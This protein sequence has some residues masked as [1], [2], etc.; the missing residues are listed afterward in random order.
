[1]LIQHR[2]S[3]N[4]CFSRFRHLIFMCF[5]LLF[6][7][8]ATHGQVTIQPFADPTCLGNSVTLATVVTSTDYGTDSYSFQVIPYAPMDTTIG[9]PID[10]TLTHCAST[11]GGKD[12]CW[13][14]PYDIGFNFCFFSQLYTQF[15]VGSNGWIGFRSPGTNP[16]NTFT[17][18]II[19]NNAADSAAPKDCIFAPWQD[20]LP[21]LSNI[22]NIFYYTIGTAPD[23]QLVVYWKN[24]PMYGC[25]TT[26]GSFQIVLKE[27]GGIIENHLQS[28]PY[29]AT[30]GNKA[31]QGVH[32]SKGTAA[33]TAVV[34]GI[35]RNQT[36]WTAVQE[37]MR[38]VPDGV[39]WHSGSATGPPLGYG[40]TLTFSPTVSTWVYSV[41][42]TCL[43]VVHYDSALVHVVPTLTGPLS[44]CKGSSGV[45]YVTEAGMTNYIWSVSAGGSVTGGGDGVSNTVTV[46]WNNAGSQTVG[47]RFTDPVT[48]CTSTVN[49][50]LSIT[51][52]D[53]PVPVMTGPQNLCLNSTG[54]LYST[55]SGKNN[56]VWTVTGGTISSGGGPANPTCTVTWTTAGAQSISV[57]YTDPV[58]LCTAL[59]PAMLPVTVNPLPTPS[60]ISGETLACKGVPGKLYETQP[61]KVNYIWNITGGTITSGG[62]S[63][64]P[65]ATV[66]WGTIGNQTISVNY[67]EPVTLCTAAAP[68][69]LPVQVVPLPVPSIAGPSTICLDAPQGIYTTQNAMNSYTWTITPITA[70]T[71]LSGAG[72]NNILVQW[73]IPGTHIVRVGYT[74]ANG[75]T[76]AAPAQHQVIVTPIPI[77]TITAAPG[78]A[79]ATQSHQYQTP[80]DPA[81]TFTWSIIPPG[82]GNIISGQGTNLISITWLTTGAATVHVTGSNNSYTCISASFIPVPV[83]PTP[84]PSFKACF[85]TKTTLNARKITLR[86]ASPFITGQGIFSG[87]GVSS[88]SPGIFEFNPLTAGPGTSL[89]SYTYTNNYG[90]SATTAAVSIMVQNVNF[91]CGNNLIDIRDGKIYS[92]AMLSGKCWMTRNLDYG[93]IIPGPY[94][95]AQ[96]DNCL[97]EKYCSPADANCTT[98]G[99]FYQWDEIMQYTT[100]PGSKGVC[101]PEWH[102][103]TETEWQTLIDNIVPGITAPDAN[104]LAGAKLKDLSATMGFHGLLGGLDYLDNFWAFTSLPLTGTMFWTST[105]YGPDQAVARG[106]NLNNPS[107]SHYN[108]SRG[109][110]YP[111]RCVKD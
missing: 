63:T 102:L 91:T 38:F 110:A 83:L 55:Q 22:N 36:N 72:T 89:I 21:T 31:T 81:C 39:S 57:L 46:T 60:F 12:D 20:W 51:V 85:D 99:G 107:V 61:G 11:S 74:D 24:C 106:V 87:T 80:P 64:N 90:C 50:I 2:W 8:F 97:D 78:I 96:T 43:G 10:Q 71:I 3:G 59:A 69:I 35:N 47:V 66:T 9:T 86:G 101:P 18:R 25:T 84:V 73:N 48:G 14:G 7:V 105:I 62:G 95:T 26:K 104:G 41:V 45:T 76:V 40:D 52:I 111:V 67:S 56:Y 33:F 17:A 37:S 77:T 28:K 15:W 70:G 103:P 93:T 19:P 53:T 6:M 92:T 27:Q 1:M 54:H 29:C 108:H 13:G 58:T 98:L 44:L 94:A 49:R 32:N 68:A 16:W 42:N 75:C 88:P 34:N 4:I 23:R 82:N 5:T 30:S 109:N 79:C 100:T 65:T